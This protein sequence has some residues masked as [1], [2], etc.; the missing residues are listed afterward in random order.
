VQIR[1]PKPHSL[2][3]RPTFLNDTGD[4]DLKLSADVRSLLLAGS[5][6]AS[7]GTRSSAATGM[8]YIDA[9]AED[10]PGAIVVSGVSSKDGDS[11]TVNLVIRKG[12][13]RVHQSVTAVTDALS[14]KVLE[15]IEGMVE[16][17]K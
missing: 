17:L 8:V 2:V 5:F 6:A 16:T 10:R 3:P 12:V 9:N 1:L 15:T 11:V 14:A 13:K 4:D 7:K